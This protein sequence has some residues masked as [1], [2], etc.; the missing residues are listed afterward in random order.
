M[1]IDTKKVRLKSLNSLRRFARFL[2]GDMSETVHYF[3]DMFTKEVLERDEDTDKNIIVKGFHVLDHGKE[4]LVVDHPNP[5]SREEYEAIKD[6][7]D[8]IEV[9][10]SHKGVC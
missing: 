8:N 9:K 7:F 10:A 4:F 5:I 2:G 3:V 6:L 1:I